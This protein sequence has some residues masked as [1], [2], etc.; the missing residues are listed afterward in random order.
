MQGVSW[1]VRQAIKYSTIVL[2]VEEWV[3]E[4]G[5]THV[6]IEQASTGGYKNQ[7]ERTMDWVDRETDDK[8]FGKVKGRSRFVK[9]GE[10]GDDFLNSGW[11]QKFLDDNDKEVIQS[12]VESVGKKPNWTA[13]QVW[14][15]EVKDGL[16][17]YTRH[18]VAKKGK[19]V[20]KVKLYY[21]WN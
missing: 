1:L 20:H 21:D 18:V 8:V 4:A 2:H 17:R 10:I 16:R 11:D 6:D 12:Y 5:H 9:L 3:D 15:F 14:G 7:E 19:E 13:D